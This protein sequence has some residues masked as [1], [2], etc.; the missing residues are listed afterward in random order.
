MQGRGTS[1]VG[2]GKGRTSDEGHETG[3]YEVP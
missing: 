3:K 2:R 1:D